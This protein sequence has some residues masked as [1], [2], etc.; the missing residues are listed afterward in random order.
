M[1]CFEGL[2]HL[3]AVILKCSISNEAKAR[4]SWPISAQDQDQTKTDWTPSKT[5]VVTPKC[6]ELQSV[7][8]I[9]CKR[10]LLCSAES[11]NSDPLLYGC[12]VLPCH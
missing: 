6:R 7:C 5:S 1:T 4:L 12:A 8:T 11:W 2:R 9:V 3:K 10:Y